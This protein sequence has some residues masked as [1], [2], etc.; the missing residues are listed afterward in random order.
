MDGMSAYRTLAL[1]RE[2]WQDI[3]TLAR[4]RNP[5]GTIR[6]GE[7]VAAVLLGARV[8]FAYEDLDQDDGHMTI[9]GDANALARA[10]VEILPAQI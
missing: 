7:H 1:A 8:G 9:W 5:T 2:R 4:R 3:A 6:I 10:V